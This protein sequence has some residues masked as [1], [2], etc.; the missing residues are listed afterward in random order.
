MQGQAE[1]NGEQQVGSAPARA[2]L[3]AGSLLPS[4]SQWQPYTATLAP[5]TLLVILPA[6]PARTR[7][8]LELVAVFLQASGRPVA[9]LG[10]EQFGA[11]RG[12]QGRFPWAVPASGAASVRASA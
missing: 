3:L 7:Q 11:G 5:E 4:R 10:A 2:V 8:A 6:A 1:H 12:I 9:V